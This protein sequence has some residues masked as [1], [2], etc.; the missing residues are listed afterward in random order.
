MSSAKSTKVMI[1]QDRDKAAIISKKAADAFLK[2]P[3]Y[4]STLT[5]NHIVQVAE[6]HLQREANELENY[7]SI[8][9]Q[10]KEF[11]VLRSTS[12][13]QGTKDSVIPKFRRVRVVTVDGD[14]MMKCSCGSTHRS[15]IPDRH[16]F[17]VARKFGVNFESFIHHDID[18]RFWTSYCKFVA[19]DDPTVM[20]SRKQSLRCELQ[21]ARR[22]LC[23]FPN[24]PSLKE[25]PVGTYIVGTCSEEK[26]FSFTS[27]HAKKHFAAIKEKGSE[28]LNY[29]G[30]DVESA[31]KA[32]YNT[33]NAA[34]MTQETYNCE[35]E[36]Q[37]INFPEADTAETL[38]H[39]R[40]LNPHA[41]FNPMFKEV[42]SLLDGVDE[43]ME[44]EIER[45]FQGMI[46]TLKGFHSARLPQPRG[47]IVSCM[48]S[49]QWAKSH[50]SKQ[51]KNSQK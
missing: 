36:D 32:E 1:D 19:T 2:T 40:P 9:I 18:P 42:L 12:T 44:N 48:P 11:W 20:D 6:S 25:M 31:L 49:N 38:D 26:F 37:I 24:A 43:E 29:T 47:S 3:L 17:H 51:K 21:Q 23:G 46:D 8:R 10:E 16:I 7:A 13:K 14:G 39:N 30:Q 15:G 28:S 35:S 33:D 22:T 27:E 34:G 50:H 41:R 5:S 45:R 4:T